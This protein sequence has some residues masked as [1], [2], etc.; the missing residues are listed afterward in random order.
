V[1][2]TATIDPEG[3]LSVADDV[4]EV[5][6][7]GLVESSAKQRSGDF[8]ADVFE[9]GGRGEVAFAEL[10][11]IEGELSLDVGMGA[12]GVID[13]RAISPFEAGKFD[14]NSVVDGIAVPNVVAEVVRERADGEGEVVG[15]LGVSQEAKDEVTRANIMSEIGEEGVAKGIVAEVLDGA[16]AVG[17]C[18]GLL[19]LRLGKGGEAFEKDGADGLLPCKIDDHFMGLDGVRNAGRG[20]QNEDEQ[21]E[22]FEWREMLWSVNLEAPGALLAHLHHTHCTLFVW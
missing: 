10:I 5:K 16:A 11:D 7:V 6:T 15:V 1:P 14:G 20:R 18:V 19:K 13:E 17:V 8:E 3:S 21:R 2:D 12:F 4:L 22:D 9:I